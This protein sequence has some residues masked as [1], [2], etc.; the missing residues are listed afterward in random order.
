MRTVMRLLIMFGPMLLRQFQKYQRNQQR[1]IPQQ[2]RRRPIDRT[3]E[4]RSEPKP[5]ERE[6]LSEEERN[7]R[8]PEEDFMLD[9]DSYPKDGQQAQETYQDN[10]GSEFNYENEDFESYEDDIENTSPILE[11][12]PFRI[13][14]LFVKDVD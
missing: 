7:F 1:Q 3:P 13:R 8:M 9:T 4:K 12:K 5:M 10:N 6:I 11:E 2:Q 14:D